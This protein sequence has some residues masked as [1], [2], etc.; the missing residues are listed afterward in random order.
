MANRLVSL[1][2]ICFM[3]I[4]CNKEDKEN[5]GGVVFWHT[6]DIISVLEHVGQFPLVYRIEDEVIGTSET[7]KF[8]TSEPDCEEN[9]TVSA[10]LPSGEKSFKVETELGDLLTSGIVT[11]S[12]DECRKI[13]LTAR[14]IAE[15]TIPTTPKIVVESVIN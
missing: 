14:V 13:Q 10:Q 12:A 4:S 7:I 15:D 5:Y 11:I 8:W 1:F 6:E 3:V 2:L 9:G